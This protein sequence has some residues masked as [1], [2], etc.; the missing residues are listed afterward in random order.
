MALRSDLSQV[1]DLILEKAIPYVATFG[2]TMTTLQKGTADAALSD[3]DLYMAFD[4]SVDNAIKHY[5]HHLDKA[6]ISAVKTDPSFDTARTPEK[7]VRLVMARIHMALLHREAASKTATYLAKPTK[8]RLGGS[9]LTKTI[10]QMW[11]CAGDK[12]T[13]FNYYTKRVLLSGVYSTTFLYALKDQSPHFE[14]TAHFLRRRLKEVSYIPKIKTKITGL[15]TSLV[16]TLFTLR[17]K[18]SH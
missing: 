10:N 13:D 3:N 12:A 15:G 1:R 16:Q 6:M 14:E 11:Y 5:S 9:L 7:I 2:W 17:G 8:L 4:G 18:S